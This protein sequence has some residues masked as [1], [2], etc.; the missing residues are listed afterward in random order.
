MQLK[1]I[2]MFCLFSPFFTISTGFAQKNAPKAGAASAPSAQATG[3]IEKGK[4]ATGPD[5]VLA[6]VG[7]QKIMLRDFEAHYQRVYNAAINPPTKAQFL[8]DLIRQEAGI[9]EAKKKGYDKDPRVVAMV[10]QSLYSGYLELELGDKA[11]KI[12]KP[13][14]AE[15]QEFYKRNPELRFSYILIEFKLGSTAEEK[16][17]AQKRATDILAEVKASKRPFAELVKLYTDDPL[18]RERG[19]DAGW[20][21][22]TSL[23]PPYYEALLKLKKNE[24]FG[25]I[26]TTAGFHIVQLTDRRSFEAADIRQ[27]RLA[28]YEENR[29]K[30]VKDLTDKAKKNHPISINSA[31][32]K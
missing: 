12:Q 27:I 2:I 10:K 14:T 24:I 31:L 7:D 29:A 8:D 18:T 13:K 32:L 17:L 26:E 28:W 25:L 1:F 9:L 11:Q 5:A 22:R 16:A 3:M 15:L 19:G 20:Q 6:T 4:N 30:L 21:T 23:V